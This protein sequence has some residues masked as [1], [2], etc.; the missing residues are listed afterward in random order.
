MHESVAGNPADI[1][2]LD[3]LSSSS[4]N[5]YFPASRSIF[6][7]LVWRQIMIITSTTVYICM[8]LISMTFSEFVWC[9]KF[10]YI[11]LLPS[12]YVSCLVFVYQHVPTDIYSVFAKQTFFPY[13]IS[14]LRSICM[15]T[16]SKHWS[17][18]TFMQCPNLI[19]ISPESIQHE[20]QDR[21]RS[22]STRNVVHGRVQKSAVIINAWICC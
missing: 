18:I 1:R 7:Q 14:M 11:Q 3:I 9:N 17:N 22:M 15:F 16:T 12:V 21:Q 10:Y 13:I 20:Q 6:G 5:R 19:Q 2:E 8:L 4:V